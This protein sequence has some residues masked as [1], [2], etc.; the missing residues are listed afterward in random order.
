MYEKEIK[1]IKEELKDLKDYTISFKS[2]KNRADKNKFNL[3][4]EDSISGVGIV[5]SSLSQKMQKMS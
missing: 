5:N 1:I 3:K 4:I 2:V